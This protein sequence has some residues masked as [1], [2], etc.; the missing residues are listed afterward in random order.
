MRIDDAYRKLPEYMDG[1]LSPAERAEMERLIASDSKLREALIISENMEQ[2]L[3]T[4]LWLETPPE[5]THKLMAQI[6]AMPVTAESESVSVW[7]HVKMALS[8][9]AL[10]AMIVFYGKALMLWSSE[11]LSGAGSWLGS[12]TG[13]SLFALHPVI[14]LGL[15][16]P[17]L[18]GGYATCV[19]T[20]RC[21]LSS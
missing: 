8:A 20:G 7:E 6:G 1:G 3:R 15:I 12:L 14:V 4:Q 11:L 17:I 9:A 2:T 10:V 21:K 19:L 5:F 16:A 18:A 13:Y